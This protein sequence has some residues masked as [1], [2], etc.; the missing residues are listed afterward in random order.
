LKSKGDKQMTV[1]SAMKSKVFQIGNRLA[2][3]MGRGKAFSFAW[4]IVLEGGLE[5]A[6]R[7]VPFDNRQEALRRLAGYKASEIRAF[8]VPEPENP[9]GKNTL[10]VMVG[11]Q[12]GRGL[13][14][15]GY[16]PATLTA[17]ARVMI[18]SLKEYIGIAAE[19]YIK[20][21]CLPLCKGTESEPRGEG[22]QSGSSEHLERVRSYV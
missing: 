17:V 19:S 15:L 16:V 6:V 11:V 13:Y 7:G 14:R 2:R 21:M 9:T 8:V 4:R 20:C 10:A 1:S 3:S 12:G 18:Q 22:M 5:L